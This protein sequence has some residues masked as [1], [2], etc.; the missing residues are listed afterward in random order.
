[1]V[2]VKKRKK[3]KKS[4]PTKEQLKSIVKKR[5]KEFKDKKIIKK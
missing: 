2:T 4:K 5:E 1:V 3:M